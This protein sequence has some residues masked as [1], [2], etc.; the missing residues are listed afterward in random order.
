[1]AKI[2]FYGGT[3]D[4]IHFGHINLAVSMKE[5]FGLDEIWFCPTPKSPLKFSKPV[6][7]F[8]DRMK[9][10]LLALENLPY[11]RVIDIEKDQSNF[12]IDTLLKLKSHFPRHQFYLI[13]GS[14]LL[15]HFHDWKESQQLIAE[16]HPVAGVRGENT[17]PIEGIKV[18]LINKMEISSTEVRERVS[19]GLYIEHLVP[20]KVVDYILCHQLYF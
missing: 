20:L 19:S 15:D 13:L 17:D 12:T 14:D 18:A 11:A 9:M 7:S 5:H 2:G 1:M 8:D 16:F 3:F 6:A 10:C 4:P